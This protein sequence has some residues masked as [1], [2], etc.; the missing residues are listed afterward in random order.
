[1]CAHKG[2]WCMAMSPAGMLEVLALSRLA[3][4]GMRSLCAPASCS[5]A[6][7]TNPRSPSSTIK[8]AQDLGERA[9]NHRVWQ[10]LS[11]SFI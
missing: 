11:L 1:V 4:T 10:A 9:S 7:K 3:G 6:T 8:Q 2:L 5:I